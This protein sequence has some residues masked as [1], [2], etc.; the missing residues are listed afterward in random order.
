MQ[1]IMIEA[2][3]PN[4]RRKGRVVDSAIQY[5]PV[6][7]HAGRDWQDLQASIDHQLQRFDSN[8]SQATMTQAHNAA[9]GRLVSAPA[10]LEESI[11]S[12]SNTAAQRTGRLQIR[13]G[14]R[15]PR[16]TSM[17]ALCT[18]PPSRSKAQLLRLMTCP[19]PLFLIDRP[20]YTI[21]EEDEEASQHDKKAPETTDGLVDRLKKSHPKLTI[22]EI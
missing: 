4:A 9:F 20:L 14:A 16:S 22:T 12:H 7:N 6:R 11:S 15:L 8:R 1:I 2:G 5:V 13:P 18:P 21:V 19:V 17:P 10:S 3:S